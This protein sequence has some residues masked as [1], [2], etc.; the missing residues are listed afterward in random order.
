MGTI[1]IEKAKA[2]G[3]E[4]KKEIENGDIAYDRIVNHETQF[5]RANPIQT[6]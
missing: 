5:I 4:C 3:Q 6:P 1:E 2:L